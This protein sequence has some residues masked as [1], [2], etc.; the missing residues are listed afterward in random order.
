MAAKNRY[1]LRLIAY[2]LVGALLFILWRGCPHIQG[3][4]SPKTDASPR[5]VAARGDLAADE[6]ATIELFEKS[7]D[8][9]VFITTKA[10]VRDRWTRNVFTVPR[11]TGSGFIWDQ[12]GH[13]IPTSTSSRGRV[14]QRSGSATEATTGPPWSGQALPMTS[15][16]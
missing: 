3:L 6:K 11:G 9:V 7:R 15:P 16:F 13:V 2:A 8:S 12:S 4:F 5:T 1:V 14:K 10:L